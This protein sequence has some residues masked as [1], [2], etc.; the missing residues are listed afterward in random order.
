MGGVPVCLDGGSGNTSIE[1]VVGNGRFLDT[2]GSLSDCYRIDCLYVVDF[3]GHILNSIS[4]FFEMHMHV[5]K[6]FSVFFWHAFIDRP[7]ASD[8]RLENEYCATIGDHMGSRIPT[9]CLEPLVRQI[10]E[11]HS[12]DIVRRCL[13]GI[14]NP[15]GANSGFSIAES[16]DVCSEI[17]L[18][19]DMIIGP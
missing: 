9:A 5:S 2:D 17:C 10:L 11:S 14:S 4:V 1:L 19:G 12:C 7:K 15:P 13:L 18:P 6:K 8:G 16:E 3:E